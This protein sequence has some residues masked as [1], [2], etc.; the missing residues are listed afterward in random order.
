MSFRDEYDPDEYGPDDSALHEQCVHQD[1]VEDTVR[2]RLAQRW[3]TE[4]VWLQLLN[5]V[6]VR[7]TGEFREAV[8][9][10]LEGGAPG[11]TC[12]CS[13]GRG[14]HTPG[15][16]CLASQCRCTEYSSQPEPDLF[17]IA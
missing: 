10:T 3:L 5:T 2:Q 11:P 16:V 12:V 13:H 6:S 7:D 14:G 15:G 8:R 17:A 9:Q 4:G 1:E